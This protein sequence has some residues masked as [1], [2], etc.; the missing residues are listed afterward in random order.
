MSRKPE[1][2]DPFDY[3][4]KDESAPKEIGMEPSFRAIVSFDE[5]YVIIRR[6]GRIQGSE[7][8]FDP[9]TIIHTINLVRA[10]RKPIT[11][12]TRSRGL[13]QKVK[14]LMEG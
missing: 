13:R 2:F 14:E 4:K 11:D 5:L 1:T 9:H 7:Q 12:V 6:M 8:V 10:G 3:I